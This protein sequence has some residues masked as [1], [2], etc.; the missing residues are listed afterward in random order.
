MSWHRDGYVVATSLLRGTLIDA[1]NQEFREDIL[2][3]G[4]VLLRQPRFA[5]EV[6][7]REYPHAYLAA[8]ELTPFGHMKQGLKDP[9]VLASH[10]SIAG[11]CLRMLC[12]AE[13]Q[14]ALAA[15]DVR[16]STYELYQSMLFDANPGTE[17]HQDCFYIDTEPRGSLVGI[18]IALEDI[19]ERAGRFYLVKGSHRLGYAL[20]EGMKN[21]D[22][23]RLIESRVQGMADS[24]VAPALRKGDAIFWHGDLIH[25][26]HPV[27]DEKFSRKSITAHYVPHGLVGRGNARILSNR[28]MRVASGMPYVV[29]TKPDPAGR[30]VKSSHTHSVEVD[31]SQICFRCIET[32]D[33][34]RVAIVEAQI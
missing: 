31:G 15:L 3:S 6:G 32:A 26:A 22:Y 18:W 20:P 9:H 19:D 2:P 16:Y 21:A 1:L 27:T 11:L 17:S 23:L 13:V 34:E 33:G 25:G 24:I 4:D 14:Q 8:H 30:R 12:G 28:V 29:T 5:R 10:P 7:P